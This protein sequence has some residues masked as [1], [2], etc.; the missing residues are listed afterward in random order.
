MS[1]RRRPA[2]L[3]TRSMD[4]VCVYI[5]EAHLDAMKVYS[6]S[7]MIMSSMRRRREGRKREAETWS[8]NTCL[9]IQIPRPRGVL[10]EG[11]RFSQSIVRNWLVEAGED[12]RDVLRPSRV[13][14]D[15]EPQCARA[16]SRCSMKMICT[17]DLGADGETGD[18]MRGSIKDEVS[19][20]AEAEWWES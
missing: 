7:M 17:G 19:S 18:G 20:R 16:E 13:C 4:E 15:R 9:E 2:V 6:V 14:A 5:Y 1:F 10:H 3:E 8:S 11:V 12:H